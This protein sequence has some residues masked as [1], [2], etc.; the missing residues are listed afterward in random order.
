MINKNNYI[1]NTKNIKNNV[2]II[3]KVVGGRVR[4]CVI[5]KANAY[6]MGMPAVVNAICQDVDYFG[7]ASV[8]E[9][10]ELRNV[11]KCVPVLVLGEVNL[12]EIEWCALNNVAVTISTLDELNYIENNLTD[13]LLRIHLAVNTGLNRLGFESIFKFKQALKMIIKSNVMTLDGCFTH[14]ATK[15]NDEDFIAKQYEIFDKYTKF[16]PNCI[17]HCANSYVTLNYGGLSCDMVRPGFAIYG[18]HVCNYKLKPALSITSE[19]IHITNVRAGSSVGYDRTFVA[20]HNM[21][22]AVIPIGYADGLDRRLSNK[23]YVLING[24]RANIVG[25]I[26]MDVALIDVTYIPYVFVG[27]KVTIIGSDGSEVITPLDIATIL[28]TSAYEVL[29]KFNYRRMNYI[30][31]SE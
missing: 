11:N 2:G 6:G 7:V 26:C 23:G 4:I 28:G 5:V 25:N 12:D 21:R 27:S 29:L 14:F 8:W 16:L 15:S 1:V 10:M 22:V 19:V 24:K 18:E 30:T 3:R 17:V 20:P 9:A 13:C 31:I